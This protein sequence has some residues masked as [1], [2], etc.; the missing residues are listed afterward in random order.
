[1]ICE[2]CQQKEATY[3]TKKI[4]NG[5]TEEHHLCADCAKAAGEGL[6]HESMMS[7][8]SSPFSFD[9]IFSSFFPKEGKSPA[10]KKESLA[11][12]PSCGLRLSDFNETGRFGCST[13]YDH[14]GR[15][16]KALLE[17]IHGQAKHVGKI[18]SVSEPL[19]PEENKKRELKRALEKAIQEEAFEKAAEL[20]D[21]LKALEEGG[22][23]K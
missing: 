22:E 8:F 3:H 7:S 9:E 20:R 15:E 1:M 11:P 5:H 12:C 23:A 16:V 2:K 4:I 13:C 17:R 10:F 19:S 21:A 6:G 14:F 18:P